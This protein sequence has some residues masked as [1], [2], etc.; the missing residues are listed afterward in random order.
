M[1]NGLSDGRFL[2]NQFDTGD[3]FYD[4]FNLHDCKRGNMIETL[5]LILLIVLIVK[6]I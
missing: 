2:H 4:L 5:V 3:N 6:V 1:D